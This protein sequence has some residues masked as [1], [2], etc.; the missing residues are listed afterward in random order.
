MP[1]NTSNKKI[2]ANRVGKGIPKKSPNKQNGYGDNQGF[3]GGMYNIDMMPKPLPGDPG[4]NQPGTGSGFGQGSG[5]EGSATPK[6]SSGFKMKAAGGGPMMKNFGIGSPNKQAGWTKAKSM[7]TFGSA[8][9]DDIDALTG[10][11]AKDEQFP[12]YGPDSEATTNP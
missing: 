4:S 8:Q 5:T 7:G 11:Q 10:G 6:K 3:K 9:Q 1:Y 2:Q 12:K